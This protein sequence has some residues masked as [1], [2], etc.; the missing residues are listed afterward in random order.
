MFVCSQ[1]LIFTVWFGVLPRPFRLVA[2]NL[3]EKRKMKSSFEAFCLERN[4]SIVHILFISCTSRGL[5]LLF[6]GGCQ[7]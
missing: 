7:L 6:S 4:P 3:P 5:S 1:T 2:E